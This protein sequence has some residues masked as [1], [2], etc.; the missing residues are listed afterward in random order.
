MTKR[1]FGWMTLG[2]VGMIAAACSAPPVVPMA[3]TPGMARPTGAQAAGAD[4]GGLELLVNLTSAR[5]LQR[6]ESLGGQLGFRVT[7]SWPEIRAAAIRLDR[8]GS[9]AQVADGLKAKIGATSVQASERPVLESFDPL[10]SQQY[11]MQ[12]MNVLG[13]WMVEPGKATTKIA[14]LDT[15]I[16]LDHPDLKGKLVPGYNAMSPGLPPTDDHGHGTHCAGIAAATAG[17]GIGGIGV[18]G[19]CSLMPVKVLSASGGSEAT[20]VDGIVW[21]TNNGAHVMSMSLGLYKRSAT[22]ERALQYALDKGVTLVASA[23]NNNT[24]NN[25][26]TKPHLPSTHPGV[27]EVTATDSAD[28]KASFSNYGQTVSVAAPGVSILSTLPGGKYGRMSGTSMAAPHVAGL[29]GLVLSKHPS[30]SPAQV[31]AAIEKGAKDVGATGFDPLYGH[32]RVDALSTVK[33]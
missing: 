17:N 29:A 30:W 31:K 32:G 4:D 33:L 22:M 13:A 9:S 8:I 5:D 10:Y 18:G 14:I 28:Q 23:G 24:E 3:G 15:G 21:A 7:K 20:I 1:Q 27:I 25:H 12:T 19:H 26:R 16:D 6:L 2:L 11:G